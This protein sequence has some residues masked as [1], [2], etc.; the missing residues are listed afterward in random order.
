[1]DPFWIHVTVFFILHII[2]HSAMFLGLTSI[3]SKI[4]R[5]NYIH[6]RFHPRVSPH[7]YVYSTEKIFVQS[8]LKKGW[9]ER[10]LLM[11]FLRCW[12]DIVSYPAQ[13]TTEVYCEFDSCYFDA[14]SHGI[15][16]ILARPFIVCPESCT[17]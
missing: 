15:H 2:N 14:W 1:M 17:I 7:I 6:I 11:L 12:G 5:R 9:L 3:I 13:L 8:S 16:S 10:S 4:N